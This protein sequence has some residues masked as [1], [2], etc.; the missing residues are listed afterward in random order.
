MNEFKK[1]V[2]DKEKILKVMESLQNAET[3]AFLASPPRNPE[4][5]PRWNDYA[6]MWMRDQLFMADAYYYFGMY[7]KLV[8]SVYPIFNILHNQRHKLERISHPRDKNGKFITSELIHAKYDAAT[9]KELTC[10][11]SVTGHENPIE[12][13]HHQLD[14]IGLFL[15]L[16]ADLNFKNID[17]RRDENDKKILQLLIFYLINVEYWQQPDFGMWEECLIKHASSI[18]AV[19]AGLSYIKRRDLATVPEEL[20]T[21]GQN[22]LFRILP[23]ES[24]DVCEREHHKWENSHDCDVAQ[25]FLIWPFNIVG[26]EMADLLLDRIINGHKA[27]NGKF[28]RLVQSFGIHRYWGDDYYRDKNGVSAQWQWDFLISIIYSQRHQYE[29]AFEWFKRGASR[30]T[31]DGHIAEAYVDGKPNDHTPLGWM[32]ALA[33]IA[34]RKLPIQTQKTLLP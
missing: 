25:L 14:A 32:H 5:D 29:T 11:N 27:K 18:G 19:V 20:I 31:D 9:L 28:H 6:A 12:W 22:Q 21:F 24:Q 16:V 13:G 15:H 30:I 17:A 2:F 4:N 1:I 34:F 23:Y 7:E 26:L 8:E 10:R 3:K 33:L